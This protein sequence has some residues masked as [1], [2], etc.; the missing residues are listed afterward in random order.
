MD[1]KVC[2]VLAT[3]AHLP[4]LLFFVAAINSTNEASKAVYKVCKA[5]YIT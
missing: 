2:Y 4:R 1:F 3:R 5:V